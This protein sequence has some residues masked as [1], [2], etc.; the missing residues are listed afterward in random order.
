MKLIVTTLLRAAPLAALLAMVPAA[1]AEKIACP[2]EIKATPSQLAT[3]V[4]GWTA[5]V[6]GV[7]T[8]LSGVT[9]YDG[10][11]EDG[12]S[13]V[14]DAEKQT[15]A[16]S[17][18]TWKFDAP[19]AKGFWIGCRY[20]NTSLT[21]ERQLPSGVKECVVTYDG[22]ATIDGAPVVQDVACR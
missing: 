9:F 3:P 12:A 17:T 18:A 22:S 15:K 2:A 11:P 13:L 16:K 4:A 1:A 7:P 6:D 10:A 20:A 5:R 14:P 8:Q 19:G 21:L